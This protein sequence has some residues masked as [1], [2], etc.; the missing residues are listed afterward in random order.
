MTAAE[1]F[2]RIHKP[3]CLEHLGGNRWVLLNRYYKPLGMDTK[4]HIDYLP[5]AIEIKQNLPVEKITWN[6]TGMLDNRGIIYLYNDSCPPWKNKES[7][8][9]YKER[10]Q[11]LESATGPITVI[12]Q[13]ET[14]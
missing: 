4:K 6:W 8:T 7:K 9:K 3:Y 2:Y 14:N 1:V 11:A 13:P 12:A 5:H 10:L